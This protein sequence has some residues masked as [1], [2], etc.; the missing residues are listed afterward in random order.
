ML[1]LPF[2]HL[3]FGG[4]LSAPSLKWSNPVKAWIAISDASAFG[5]LFAYGGL[6]IAPISLGV[7]TV[8]LFSYGAFA[9]GALAVGTFGVGVWAFGGNAFGWQACGL[10]AIAWDL[11]SGSQCAIAYHFANGPYLYSSAAQANTEF[12]KHLVNSNPFIQG[13][14]KIAPYYFWKGMWILIIPLM[15]TNL[16]Q[17]RVAV[18]KAAIL[19]KKLKFASVPRQENKLLTH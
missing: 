14:W 13:C 7:C 4:W 19:L 9:Y 17:W 3:R 15:I 11:A 5:V 6:A 12:V 8:G 1:G 18:K 10:C 2:I 16:V